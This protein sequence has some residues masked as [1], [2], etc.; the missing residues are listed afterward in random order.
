MLVEFISKS[1]VREKRRE[2]VDWLVKFVVK[3]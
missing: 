1:E 2:M 3:H